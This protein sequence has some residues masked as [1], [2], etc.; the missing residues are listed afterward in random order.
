MHKSSKQQSY[1]QLL[2]TENLLMWMNQQP[3]WLG[4]V[5][6]GEQDHQC[7]TG[8]VCWKYVMYF[9]LVLIL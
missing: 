2:S 8:E 4:L 7:P 3:N 6:H 5:L 9:A 1:L